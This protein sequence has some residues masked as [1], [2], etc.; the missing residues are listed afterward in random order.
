MNAIDTTSTPPSTPVT[1]FICGERGHGDDAIAFAILDA[2]PAALRARV[3]VV[4]EGMLDAGML[5]ELPDDAAAVVVD[6]LGGVVPGEVASMPLAAL[7]RVERERAG[8]REAGS[9]RSKHLKS[10][11]AAITLAEMLLGEPV[12]GT[13]VG[14]GVRDCAPGAPLS[15]DVAAALPR[16]A[17]M[18]TAA[19]EHYLAEQSARAA[20]R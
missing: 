9:P 6:A 12:R 3:G 8:G 2:L 5:L 4:Q 16:A 1:L 11:D 17:A 15:P 13:F 7:A 19:I 20:A 10:I 14:V 18:V